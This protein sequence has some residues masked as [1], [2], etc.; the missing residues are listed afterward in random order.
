VQPPQQKK[1]TSEPHIPA[2][3]RMALILLEIF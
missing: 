1:K 2:V 3:V